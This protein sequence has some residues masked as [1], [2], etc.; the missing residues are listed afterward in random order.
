VQAATLRPADLRWHRG[1][2]C[3][4]GTSGH[5]NAYCPGA[6]VNN[7]IED[8]AALDADAAGGHHLGLGQPGCFETSY[9]RSYARSAE[10]YQA[11]L[12]A[13]QMASKTDLLKEARALE[14]TYCCKVCT[15]MDC[16][17]ATRKG[18]QRFRLCSRRTSS[19]R[20]QPC[21]K[22]R[23]LVAAMLLQDARYVRPAQIC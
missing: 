22:K 7:Y 9:W 1:C 5:K 10:G 8:R 6:L 3:G 12:K 23:A 17:G 16:S 2:G 15:V 20:R 11:A 18:H 14:S 21:W 13:N 19:C 4:I